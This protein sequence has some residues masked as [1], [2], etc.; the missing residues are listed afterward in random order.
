[1]EQ[2]DPWIKFIILLD[3]TFIGRFEWK[4]KIKAQDSS[5]F[6]SGEVK[7]RQD[8][9]IAIWEERGG[10]CLFFSFKKC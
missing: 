2:Y 1:M 6:K 3:S 7:R 9:A 5:P 4:R 10:L 8:G